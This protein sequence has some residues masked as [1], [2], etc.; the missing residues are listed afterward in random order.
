MNRAF[1]PAEETLLGQM[2]SHFQELAAE[3]GLAAAT[4]PSTDTLDRLW[5]TW[6]WDQVKTDDDRAIAISLFGFAFGDHVAA[7]TG[8]QWRIVTD[9]NGS[10]YAL[11]HPESDVTAFP[12]ATV[13]KRLGQAPFFATL[14]PSLI[15]D[16]RAAASRPWWRFW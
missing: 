5:E 4:P 10:D 9:E 13:A 8:M 6:S 11:V 7:E 1:N 12:L 14:A 2:R 15:A 16:A 3:A